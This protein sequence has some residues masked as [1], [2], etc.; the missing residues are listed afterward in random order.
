MQKKEL[1]KFQVGHVNEPSVD[2]GGWD[3]LIGIWYV[4]F[5]TDYLILDQ[6]FKLFPFMQTVIPHENHMNGFS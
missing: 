6:L 4:S 2:R 5:Y 1:I 3:I